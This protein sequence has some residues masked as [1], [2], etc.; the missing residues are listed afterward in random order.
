MQ[1]HATPQDKPR[2]Q[3]RRAVTIPDGLGKT[4]HSTRQVSLSRAPW[5]SAQSLLAARPETAPRQATLRQAQSPQKPSGRALGNMVRR[6]VAE[7]LRRLREE[8]EP[9]EI[10]F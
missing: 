5:D 7:E 9:T 8:Q 3:D 6:T 2:R 1:T 4:E 10:D